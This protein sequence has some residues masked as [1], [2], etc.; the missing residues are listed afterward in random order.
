MNNSLYYLFLTITF[1]TRIMGLKIIAV[2][3]GIGILLTI[4]AF[5]NGF[6]SAYAKHDTVRVDCKDLAIALIT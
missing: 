1:F 3:I 6:N 5:G 4:T 2:A